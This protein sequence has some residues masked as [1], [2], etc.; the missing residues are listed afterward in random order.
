MK[1]IGMIQDMTLKKLPHF[2][3]V[4]TVGTLMP[5]AG[6]LHLE[7]DLI[8][9]VMSTISLVHVARNYVAPTPDHKTLRDY[10]KLKA[11]L[12]SSKYLL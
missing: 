10:I 12:K 8:S 3:L 9:A 5:K 7:K 11:V 2:S 1:M 6:V 4:A